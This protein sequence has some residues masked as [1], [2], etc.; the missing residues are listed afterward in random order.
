MEFTL[1]NLA[2]NLHLELSFEA[3]EI[4]SPA[5]RIYVERWSMREGDSF[6]YISQDCATAS[7]LDRVVD[8][9]IGELENIRKSGRAKFASCVANDRPNGMSLPKDQ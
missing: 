7:E 3:G 2:G 9:L 5:A 4:V 8:R 1:Q 6:H